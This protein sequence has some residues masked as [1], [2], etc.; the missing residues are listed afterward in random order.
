MDILEKTQISYHFHKRSLIS[1]LS[2]QQTIQLV[3][4]DG[5]KEEIWFDLI[6]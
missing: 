3:L 4:T 1:R 6:P 2:T 5:G